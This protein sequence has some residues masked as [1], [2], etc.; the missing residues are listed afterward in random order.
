MV[1]IK[2]IQVLWYQML[3]AFS[4]PVFPDYNLVIMSATFGIVI[5][6]NDEWFYAFLIMPP[7]AV[8]E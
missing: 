4:L 3:L 6:D 8:L 2:D 5:H 7:S 1:K